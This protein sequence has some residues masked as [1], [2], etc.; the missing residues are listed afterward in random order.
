M[1]LID[2]TITRLERNN[3]DP[4]SALLIAS[5][6]LLSAIFIMFFA[7]TGLVILISN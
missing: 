1:K 6:M 7:V 5:L 3:T 2:T 4:D